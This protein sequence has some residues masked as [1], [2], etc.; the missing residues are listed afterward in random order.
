MSRQV[1]GAEMVP[2]LVTHEGTPNAMRKLS[3]E[4]ALERI[5]NDHCIAVADVQARALRR[6]VWVA[7]WHFFGCISESQSYHCTKA[8][9]VEAALSFGG[10][11]RGMRTA[12]ERNGV[13]SGPAWGSSGNVQNTTISKTTLGELL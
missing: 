9:A 11:P 13:W 7:E 4:E 3:F 10:Y 2:F 8:E 12:L 6:K 5:N 1:P